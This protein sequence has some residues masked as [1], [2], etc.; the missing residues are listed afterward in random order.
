MKQKSR[1]KKR[2]FTSKCTQ[3]F[4]LQK[5]TT[6]VTPPEVR[7]LAVRHHQ[8][9]HLDLVIPSIEG[10][11]DRA[12]RLTTTT[13][14]IN[15]EGLDQVKRKT[16]Q[17]HHEIIDMMSQYDDTMD[18]VFQLNFQVPPLSEQIK[19]KPENLKKTVN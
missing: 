13:F 3:S 17:F 1:M 18:Q 7:N 4:D 19:K 9:Q 5:N 12:H 16:D 10:S 6:L 2:S 11:L 15:E 14:G 8:E